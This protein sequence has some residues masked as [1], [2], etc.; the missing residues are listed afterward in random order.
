MWCPWAFLTTTGRDR[1]SAAAGQHTRFHLCTSLIPKPM[2]VVIGLGTRLV[3]VRT[4]LE[5][6]VLHNG[7]QP[8]SAVDSFFDHSKFEA[9]YE[10]IEWLVGKLHAV[11]SIC[12]VLKSMWV[13]EPFLSY[14]C[15][16]TSRN[17]ETSVWKMKVDF[18]CLWWT[19]HKLRKKW[20]SY[21]NMAYLD[22]VPSLCMSLGTSLMPR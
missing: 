5:N 4:R 9:T 20:S 22:C 1:A 7:Q 12:Y 13:L 16:N 8:G 11:M 2:T 10:V 18:I 6:G 19:A 15:L 17:K 21:F 14:R 3:H